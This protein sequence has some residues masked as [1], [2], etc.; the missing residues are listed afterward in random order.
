MTVKEKSA[1]DVGYSLNKDVIF[2]HIQ[3]IYIENFR[4]FKNRE[5]KLGRYLTVIT[6]KNGTMK[7][8]LLGLIAHPFSSP[9]DA[10]DSFGK[11][12]K[13][14]MRHIFKLSFS[15]DDETFVYYLKAKTNTNK[16]F[17]EKVKLYPRAKEDRF[18]VTVGRDHS[19]GLGNFFLNTSFIGLN[20]LYPI[21][22]TKAV[23]SKDSE[24]DRLS[25]DDQEWIGNAYNYVIQKST[26]AKTEKVSDS[27]TKATYGPVQTYYN[28]ETMSSGEDNLGAIFNKMIAFSKN[29]KFEDNKGLN[30]ILCIDEIEASLH[31]VSQTRLVSFLKKWA[32]KNNVQVVIT[33]HSLY[34][35]E[36]CIDLQNKYKDGT[37][38][39]VLNNISTVS[40]GSDNNYNVMINPSYDVLY[41][42]LTYKDAEEVDALN[43]KVNLIVEDSEAKDYINQILFRK[44]HIKDSFTF[45]YNLDD[46]IHKGDG[47]KTLV[48]LAKKAKK[49]LK[50]SI[51][52]VDPDVTDEALKGCD[53]EYIFKI[54]DID[55]LSLP[56][57]KRIVFFIHN[58]EGDDEFFAKI[59]KE[60]G[61]LTTTILDKGIDISN[62]KTQSTANYKRWV[63]D[64]RVFFDE[65]LRMYIKRNRTIFNEFEKRLVERIN[66]RRK[67]YSLPPIVG[68]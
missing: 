3:G 33:T 29:R 64:N 18:R 23:A 31:P 43:H 15:S 22:D 56:I 67:R 20:R 37:T 28:F 65:A 45:M 68:K 62:I 30:G 47:W 9:N 60:K 2:D 34:V 39:I 17:A 63:T 59:K 66:S 50:D 25:K 52:I 53:S 58:L 44:K 11:A 54:P 12:L 61:F 48:G 26:F 5:I 21:I 38:D 13:T 14:D 46:G 57:E 24:D 1:R 27:I 51:I 40:V 41:K 19:E 6:G 42:E 4:S 49:L 32:Y 8:S 16:E 36:H 55:S 7:S 10:K 35:I